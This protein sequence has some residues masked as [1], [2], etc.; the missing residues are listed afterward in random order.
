MSLLTIAAFV[1]SALG[2]TSGGFINQYLG[3]RYIQY[4]LVGLAAT[5]TVVLYFSS[6]TRGSKILS[7]RE[8]TRVVRDEELIHFPLTGAAKLRKDTGSDRYQCK[9]DAERSSLIVLIKVSMTRPLC[10]S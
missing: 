3:W 7:D 10:K 1:G 4:I 9:S 2:A 5:M 6:E 8:S